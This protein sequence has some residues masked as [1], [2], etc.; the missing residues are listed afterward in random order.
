MNAQILLRNAMVSG[1]QQRGENSAATDDPT[2]TDEGK[3]VMV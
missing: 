1:I 3:A 2:S